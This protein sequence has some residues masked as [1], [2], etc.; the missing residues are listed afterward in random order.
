MTFPLTA[1]LPRCRQNA[2]IGLYLPPGSPRPPFSDSQ[3]TRS[4]NYADA[5][6]IVNR[7]YAMMLSMNGPQH[8][9]PT[10][11]STQRGEPT[12]SRITME[13]PEPIWHLQPNRMR[14]HWKLSPNQ[15]RLL[16]PLLK[17]AGTAKWVL[18]HRFLCKVSPNLET[19]CWDWVGATS[20]GYAI[21]NMGPHRRQRSIR[22]HRVARELFVG[23]YPPGR[24]HTD[25]LCRNRRCVNPDHLDA[26]TVAEN[27]RRM[28]EAIYAPATHCKRG[29][30]WADFGTIHKQGFRV[31]RACRHRPPRNFLT[32]RELAK[33]L[34]VH[35]VTIGRWIK[36]GRLKIEDYGFLVG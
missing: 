31:C 4:W 10:N 6:L 20:Q 30:L 7:G 2:R 15:E 8:L 33:H 28:V 26:V 9:V 34:D 32:Q 24:P 16:G 23:P 29:H 21:L 25:H 11:F 12:V 14:R 13:R 27:N 1:S 22:A 17:D 5:S 19:G 3:A 35:Q 18:A 36:A